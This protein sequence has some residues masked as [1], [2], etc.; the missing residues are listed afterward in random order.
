[1]ALPAGKEG[2]VAPAKGKTDICGVVSKQHAEDGPLQIVGN[3]E[4]LGVSHPAKF[5]EPGALG[6]I[7]D[8]RREAPSQTARCG[9]AI[10]RLC[11][12]S[13]S[14]GKIVE[15]SIIPLKATVPER[16]RGPACAMPDY[17]TTG[18]LAIRLAPTWR[19]CPA[20]HFI[21]RVWHVCEIEAFCTCLSFFLRIGGVH[22]L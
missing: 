21:C 6:P 18:P 20:A 17:G 12:D 4:S 13:A 10:G 9:K 3:H 14:I 7:Q 22:I 2:F 15:N 19:G 5:L 11:P 1:M 16:N 8:F